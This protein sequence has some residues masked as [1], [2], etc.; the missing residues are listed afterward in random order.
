MFMIKNS[1]NVRG[2]RRGKT[3]KGSMIVNLD[4][5]PAGFRNSFQISKAHF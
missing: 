3:K 1:I 2:P 4:C 5:Q